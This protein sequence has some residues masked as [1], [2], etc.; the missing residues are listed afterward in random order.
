MRKTFGYVVMCA[1]LAG[2]SPSPSGGDVKQVIGMLAGAP[3]PSDGDVKQIVE[4]MLGGCPYLSLQKFKKLN[5]VP[6]GEGRYAV[7]VVFTVKV[8]PIPGAKELVDNSRADAT[9]IGEK[10]AAARSSKAQ[11]AAKERDY[12]A[13]IAQASQSRDTALE[14]A[15]VTEK[16]DFVNQTTRL[17]R[18]IDVL[19]RQRRATD[20]ALLEPIHS[21]INQ[22]CPSVHDMIRVYESGNLDQYSTT[23]TKDFAGTMPLMKTDNGWQVAL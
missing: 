16:I 3:S 13:R 23:F 14:T 11:A 19:E 8:A 18:E 7:D 22:D 1:I 10:L 15:L 20:A 2:C 21:R 12:D 17:D 6:A 9:A 5:G 4:G